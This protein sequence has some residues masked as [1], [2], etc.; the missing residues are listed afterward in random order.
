MFSVIIEKHERP[1][2]NL[3]YISTLSNFKI[4]KKHMEK[5][6]RHYFKTN[7]RKIIRVTLRFTPNEMKMIEGVMSAM[8]RSDKTRFLHNS[9]MTNVCRIRDLLIKEG[10][11]EDCILQSSQPQP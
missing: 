4:A 1:P 7:E 2:N 9:L 6:K 5:P 8:N 10:A 3:A 11:M